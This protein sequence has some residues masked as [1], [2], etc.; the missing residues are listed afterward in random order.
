[1]SILLLRY[2]F[3]SYNLLPSCIKGSLNIDDSSKNDT[4][5]EPFEAYSQSIKHSKYTTADCNRI[6]KQK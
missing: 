3:K 4:L 5:V 2:L 6:I 1:M